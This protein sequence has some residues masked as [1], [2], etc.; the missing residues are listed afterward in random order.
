V[1]YQVDNG[2]DYLVVLGTTGETATLTTQEKAEVRS[3]VLRANAGRLPVV[4]GIGGNSTQAVVEEI[5]ATDLSGFKAVLSVS[6]YYNKPSQEGIYRHFKEVSSA[7]DLPVIIYN[8]PPRTGSNILPETTL[9]LARDFDNI[10]AVKEASGDFEQ[11]LDLLR[12][13]PAD[14]MIISGEDKLALPLVLAG[15]AGVISVIGQGLP[16]EFSEMIRLGLDGR[17]KEAF[18]VFYQVLDSIDLIFEEGNPSGIKCLLNI[19]EISSDSVRL[20]LVPASEDLRQKM[21]KFVATLKK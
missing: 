7:S 16:K 21:I 3:C 11:A 20:P 9:R 1:H 13:K 8:V 10:I 2:V 5:R 4:L 19:L 6:P 15:G 17:S 18:E 14:F 12:D